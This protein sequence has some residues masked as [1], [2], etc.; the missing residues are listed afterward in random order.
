MA[1][2]IESGYMKAKL[3]KAAALIELER[4]SDAVQEY[5]DLRSQLPGDE[6][7]A[8]SLYECKVAE[9]KAAGNDVSSIPREKAGVI[10]VQSDTQYWQLVRSP[11][12]VVVDFTAS[13][14]GPCRNIAPVVDRM[15]LQCPRIHFLKVRQIAVEF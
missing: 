8:K 15:A 14:C 3:R 13:W 11:G 9:A 2:E 7:I 5:S 12:L 1:V 4:F 10:H 6:E